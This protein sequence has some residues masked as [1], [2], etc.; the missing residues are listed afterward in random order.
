MCTFFCGA[1]VAINGEVIGDFDSYTGST[2]NALGIDGVGVNSLT[3]TAV[4]LPEDDW[5]SLLEVSPVRITRRVAFIEV[6]AFNMN[7]L[8]FRGCNGS[9]CTQVAPDSSH[10]KGEAEG[11]RAPNVRGSISHHARNT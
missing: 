2:F 1:Q 3:L 5:I 11:L 7:Y 10:A 6:G 8:F 4:G 9:S